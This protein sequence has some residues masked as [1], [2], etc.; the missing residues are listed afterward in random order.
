MSHLSELRIEALALAVADRLGRTPGLQT[1]DRGKVVRE[2]EKR[3]KTAFQADSNLDQQVRARIESL[4]RQVPEGSREWEIL[5][6][7]Y[8]EE[9][10]RR[11]A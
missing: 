11:R 10:A 4:S 5:Y 9:L 1:V 3:L 2:V 7:Q 6:R 8:S